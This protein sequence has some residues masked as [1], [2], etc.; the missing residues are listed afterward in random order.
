MGFSA[1]AYPLFFVTGATAGLVDSIA[2]GGGLIALPM[3]LTLGIP[4]PIALGTNKLQSLIGTSIAS[5]HFARSG[6]IDLPAC[7]RGFVA[8]FLGSLAGAWTIERLDPHLLARII[9]WF[10]ALVFFYTLLRKNLGT[11]EERPLMGKPAFYL[12]A[13]SV[14]GFYDG[15]FGPGVGSFWTLALVVGLGFDFLKATG[16]TKLMNAASNLAAVIL[17]GVAGHIAWV[18]ALSMAAGQA[19]GARLGAG[20]ALKKGARFV[21]PLFLTMV[22][23]TLARLVY[24]ATRP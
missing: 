23:L 22:G 16:T 21:R 17:F 19:L 3:I 24:L 14:L 15:F 20:V 4:A 7:R 8:S 9:P 6:Q 2:G 12:A 11:Q 10:L 18:A 13:G 5:R 1:W